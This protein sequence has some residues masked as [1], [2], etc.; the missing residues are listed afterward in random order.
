V[1]ADQTVSEAAEVEQLVPVQ[2]IAGK[3]GDV[4]GEYDPDIAEGD[5]TDQLGEARPPLGRAGGQAEVVV[6]N[7]DC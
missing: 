4:I 7:I 6:D 3:P 2:A 5:P 1:I